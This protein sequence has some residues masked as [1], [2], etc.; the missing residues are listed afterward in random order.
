M[1]SFF[2]NDEEKEEEFV[3]YTRIPF[4]ITETGIS[5]DLIIENQKNMSR[6]TVCSICLE[7]VYDPVMCGKCENLFCRNCINIQLKKSCKCPN[8]CLFEERPI[9]RVLKNLLNKFELYCYYKGNGCKEI[10]L[11]SEFENHCKNCDYGDF[12]CTSPGC[13]FSGIRQKIIEHCKICP[14]KLISCIYCKTKIVRK[15]YEEHKKECENKKI[16]CTF[17]NG[18][19]LNKDMKNHLNNDCDNVEIKCNNCF[20]KFKRKEYKNHNENECLKFQ[21]EYWKM[22]ATNKDKEIQQLKEQLQK[23]IKKGQSYIQFAAKVFEKN[24][25]IPESPRKDLEEFLNEVHIEGELDNNQNNII[26][27]QEQNNYQED[28]NTRPNISINNKYETE[29]IIRKS[30]LS[31]LI[32]ALADLNEF[33]PGLI[34]CG[35]F[36]T[37]LFLNLPNLEKKFSLDG[38]SSYIWSVIYLSKY[39][40]NYIASSSQDKTIKIWDLSQRKCI[41][42]FS[43][44]TN[45][46][47]TLSTYNPNPNLL[48]STSYDHTLSIW[49]ISRGEKK[50]TISGVYGK[51][52]GNTVSFNPNYI[53][54]GS[55]NNHVCVYDY[56]NRRIVTELKGHTN[57]T[58]YY[59]DL[60]AF[61]HNL[62]ATGADDST[63][64]IWNLSSSR[65]VASFHG[66][67]LC[68]TLLVHLSNFDD[69][70]SLLA[71]GSD[72]HTLRLWSLTS[73]QCVSVFTYDSWVKSLLYLSEPEYKEYFLSHGETGV[74]KFMKLI[75]I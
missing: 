65:L 1:I 62:I 70:H 34:C 47:T 23:S 30:N 5:T 12:R 35:D 69:S 45:W 50:D 57:L 68:I 14:F 39:N 17:C 15:N 11:Y 21:V 44:H 16:K 41:K 7:M 75:K 63:I 42:T 10:I 54:Y 60:G 73:Y 19:Y 31:G 25:N 33:S 67:S 71:S 74:I 58:N 43:E 24:K 26:S 61:D 28:S 4:N 27:N 64:K 13:D 40:R 49:D 46:V 18:I 9:N 53:L 22:E 51:L 59:A 20:T 52:C 8:K 3:D 48:L 2:P 38:H 56:P 37:L 72:D 32:Y 55:N 6:E 66:H 36:K 29:L